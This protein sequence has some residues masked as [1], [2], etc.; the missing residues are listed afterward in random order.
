MDINFSSFQKSERKF[1]FHE[2]PNINKH[3]S[4][5]TMHCVNRGQRCLVHQDCWIL[6]ACALRV[7]VAFSSQQLKFQNSI[8]NKQT[9]RVINKTHQCCRN[10]LLF[11]LQIIISVCN[12]KMSYSSKSMKKQLIADTTGK[13]RRGNVKSVPGVTECE[14]FTSC[15]NP[16]LMLL[17]VCLGESF[18]MLY[19]FL[20]GH[21]LD[22]K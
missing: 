15:N 14:E 1:H 5:N 7:D 12:T 17:E 8:Q 10:F 4:N 9:K 16:W 6:R 19:N 13:N 2:K 3:N 22:P 20:F 11:S 21:N 18:L